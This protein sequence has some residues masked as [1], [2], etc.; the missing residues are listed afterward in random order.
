MI[1]L[2]CKVCNKSFQAKPYRINKAKFC[3]LECFGISI[4]GIHPKGEFKKGQHNSPQ[5]EFHKG[6]LH[7][8]FGKSSFALG[9]HWKL[10][11]ETK[12][13]MSKV[14]KYKPHPKT[15]KELHPNWKGGISSVN[16][17][18]RG[19]IN[20]RLWREQVYLYDDWTC[21]ICE[22]RGGKL[23]PH[24]LKKFSEFPEARFNLQNGIT[25]CEFC[26]YTYG[27]HQK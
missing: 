25:L 3:S 11:K 7:P 21:W 9:K 23:H 18:I 10:S 13:R 2:I 1:K 26:H 6:N 5:T 19:S 4:K 8:Y 15:S 20:Y 22:N 27:N 16:K 12:A 24:H 14:Q 17:T